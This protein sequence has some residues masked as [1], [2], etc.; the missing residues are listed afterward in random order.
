[1]L[2]KKL[3]AGVLATMLLCQTGYSEDGDQV[4]LFKQ[5]DKNNDGVVTADEVPAEKK[6][7]FKRLMRIGDKNK[8]NKLTRAELTS[9][10]ADPVESPRAEERPARPGG[11]R[12]GGGSGQ[13][14]SVDAIFKQFDANKDGKLTK[15]E[16]PQQAER[17]QKLVQAADKD[18]NGVITRQELTQA[19]ATTTGQGGGQQ[20]Q[21]GFGQGGQQR[22]GQGQ[23]R[24]G[25]GGGRPSP[26]AMFT[27]FDTNKD[28]KLTKDEIPQQSQR[29]LQMMKDADKDKDGAITQKELTQYLSGG[30]GQGGGQRPGGGQAGGRPQPGGFGGGRPGAGGGGGRSAFDANLPKVGTSLPNLIAY[31]ADGK[32]FKLSEV[33][34]KYSVLVFGCLT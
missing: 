34:G 18:R 25:Q 11:Q 20:R 12:P 13:G 32:E 8:D 16:V 30:G 23:Q 14:V 5:L 7:I 28:G 22:G 1:M 31:N 29:L 2:L 19:L 15:D 21:G 24:G 3:S 9:A 6:Q 4:A 26:E 17:L 27:R 10:L 33:K